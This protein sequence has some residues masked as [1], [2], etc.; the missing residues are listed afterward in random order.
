MRSWCILGLIGL[1]PPACVGSCVIHDNRLAWD[2]ERVEVG[3]RRD[4]VIGVLG[5]PREILDCKAPGPFQP[6]R[7]RDCAETYLYPTWAAPILPS[8]WAVWLNDRGTVIGKYRF[9][10]W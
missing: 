7:R 10:S 5:T 1:L 6:W 4:E 8:M 3:M 2:F 9:V